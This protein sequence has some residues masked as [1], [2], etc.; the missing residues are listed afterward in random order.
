MATPPPGLFGAANCEPR[1]G[2]AAG[3]RG[4]ANRPDSDRIAATM[5]IGGQKTAEK[6]QKR[7]GLGLTLPPNLPMMGVNLIFRYV[8]RRDGAKHALSAPFRRTNQ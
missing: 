3:R 4:P 5:P 8:Q 7:P 1:H 6:K 2:G